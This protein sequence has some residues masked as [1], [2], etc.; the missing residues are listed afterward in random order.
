MSTLPAKDPRLTRVVDDDPLTVESTPAGLAVDPTPADA[1]FVRNNGGL[2]A[3]GDDW[4]VEVIGVRRPQIVPVGQLWEGLPRASVAAVLQCAGNGRSRLAEPA[5][6]VQWG[7]GGMGCPEWSGVRLAEVVERHGG[8]GDDAAFLTVLGGD[9][10]PDD[11]ERVERSIPLGVALERALLAD[12]LDGRPVPFVHGGPVRLVVP[13]YYAV[14]SVKWVRRIAFTA[15]ESDALIQTVRYRLAPPGSEPGP[16]HPS[17]WA[18]GPKA[19]VTHVVTDPSGAS[20]VGGVA[21]TGDDAVDRVDVTA[22][23]GDSWEEAT[24]GAGRGPYAWRRFEARLPGPARRVAAR[25]TAGDTV[26][27]R[28]TVPTVDG[29]AVDGWH[30]LTY[31]VDAA[32]E[33]LRPPS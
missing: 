5:P 18:M 12:T 24:L 27:P 1:L 4:P 2:P 8:V 31:E 32:D 16:E 13:G 14:N 7:M 22:D 26:Q 17:L 11:P 15:T 23:D 3:I 21:F 6:G 30:H 25:A 20:V 29:Y 33:A 19:V 28:A 9:A 10:S